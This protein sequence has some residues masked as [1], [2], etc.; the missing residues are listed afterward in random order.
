MLALRCTLHSPLLCLCASCIYRYV[1][2]SKF[3]ILL[4]WV[5]MLY[6]KKLDTSLEGKRAYQ[7]V[8]LK[9]ASTGE[10]TVINF[11]LGLHDES[12]W[13]IDHVRVRGSSGGDPNGPLRARASDADETGSPSG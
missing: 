13:L 3:K 5:S 4:E 2:E 12:L 10:W 1:Q 6:S 8:R 7:E 9:S 11:M